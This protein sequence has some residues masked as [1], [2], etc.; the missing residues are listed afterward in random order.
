MT[1]F[2]EVVIACIAL[3]G[4]SLPAL[5]ADGTVSVIG[6][7]EPGLV[8]PMHRAA[9]GHELIQISTLHR[10]AVGLMTQ[11]Q[12]VAPEVIQL[13]M[14]NLP[15][16]V[17]PDRDYAR[18]TGG[19]DDGH[20]ILRAQRAYKA[21]TARKHAYIIR[22]GELEPMAEKQTIVPRAILIRPD[23]LERRAPQQPMTPAPVPMQPKV[24]QGPVAL[25]E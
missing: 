23:Y 7:A 15:I 1:R 9:P 20:S 8:V 11:E 24:E 21:M 12:G 3:G 22:R 25:A 10:D 19:I 5:A 13:Q 18:A 17:D 16:F 6:P 4:V 14:G 2:R